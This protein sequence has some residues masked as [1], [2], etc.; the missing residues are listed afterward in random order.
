MP[1]ELLSLGMPWLMKA[2]VAY[3]L[4]AVKCTLFTDAA[5]PTIT[6]SNTLAFTVNSP[7][8]LTGGSA[9]V[10]GAFLKATTDTLVTLKRD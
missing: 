8:T 5:S 4:P 10:I 6:A 1:T 2:G 3:A 7:V 9:T